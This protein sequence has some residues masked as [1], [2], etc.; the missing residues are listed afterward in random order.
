MYIWQ[1]D[2]PKREYSNQIS[3]V[4][5]FWGIYKKRKLTSPEK[6]YVA[7]FEAKWKKSVDLMNK[8]F[9][10]AE[11]LTAAQSLFWEAV[12][13]ADDVID[14]EIQAHLAKRISK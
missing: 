7:E 1:F 4:K 12:H 2:K 5:E 11:K 10:D 8:L 3:A 6:S 13:K 14:F 9:K